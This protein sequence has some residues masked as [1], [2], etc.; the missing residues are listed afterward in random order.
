MRYLGVVRRPEYRTSHEGPL[1]G[2]ADPQPLR[3]GRI[4]PRLLPHRGLPLLPGADRRVGRLSRTSD[5]LRR[6]AGFGPA[7]KRHHGTAYA[8]FHPEVRE[9]DDRG[10][11]RERYS[12]GW[13]TD[14]ATRVAGV[15]LRT[16]ATPGRAQPE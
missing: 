6:P 13:A 1:D 7:S 8:G 9:W 15:H 10:I 4:L 5:H 16:P 3:P 14:R 11:D 2:P 12:L